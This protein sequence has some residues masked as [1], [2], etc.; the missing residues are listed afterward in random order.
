MNDTADF[1][2]IIFD[3]D[4]TLM[5]SEA[6]IVASARAA[7]HDL[8]LPGLA[9]ERVRNIIGLGLQEASEALFPGRDAGFHA[10]FI[11]C[12]RH[13]FL[14]ADQTP[15]PLFEGAAETLAALSEDG[16][17]LAVATGKA[18]RG[19]NRVMEETGLEHLFGASRCA[20]EAPSKPHPQ[21]LREIMDELG[22]GGAETV[23][24]G[25]TEYDLAMARN[26]GTHA[27]AVSY[28][29]HACERLLQFA[30]LTC[31]DRISELTEWL[32]D[33]AAD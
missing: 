17:L 16:Y 28:G 5:D 6:K 14:V 18:R 29:V 30:P 20:D 24:V 27:I 33:R 10:R 31:L 1:K 21:M 32:R 13:H 7:A 12:Y 22:V 8:A 4:G 23:M 26:A 3:W 25:D 19:L 9:P 11:E 15:M 2:L